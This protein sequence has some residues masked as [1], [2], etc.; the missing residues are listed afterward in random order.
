MQE[1]TQGI[2]S[3]ARQLSPEELSSLETA[4][5]TVPNP[6]SVSMSKRKT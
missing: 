3:Q 2:L 5:F 1:L 6:E 4:Q